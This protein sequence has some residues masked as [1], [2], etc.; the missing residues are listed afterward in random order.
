MYGIDIE[1][2]A[3]MRSRS[4]RWLTTRIKGLFSVD[5][6]ISRALAPPA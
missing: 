4:G 2:K 3:L 1:D 6:R 5:S